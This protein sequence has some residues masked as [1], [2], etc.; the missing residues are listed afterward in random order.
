MAYQDSFEVPCPYC[1]E[2]ISLD[3]DY[4]QGKEQSFE[5]DCP[6]CCRPI[7]IHARHT[8]DSIEAEAVRELD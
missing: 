2:T 5:F 7:D 4:S 1:S 8:A 3:F 6:V